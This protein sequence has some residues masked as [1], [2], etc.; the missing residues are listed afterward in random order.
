MLGG[1]WEFPGGKRQAGETIEEAGRREII[2]ELGLEVAVGREICRVNH[3]YSH[4]T[5][6][7]HALECRPVKGRPR[8]IAC[9]AVKWVAERRLRDYPFPGAD[10]QV[11]DALGW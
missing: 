3:A 6:T 2:E 4:F 11:L 5:M 8:P 10:R 1:M 7:L 9:A